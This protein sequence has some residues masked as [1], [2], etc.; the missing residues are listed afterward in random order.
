MKHATGTRFSQYITGTGSIVLKEGVSIEDVRKLLKSQ[1][2]EKPWLAEGVD[3]F[4]VK[5]GVIFILASYER[6]LDASD[7]LLI[8]SGFRSLMASGRLDFAASTGESFGYSISSG[9]K[10]KPGASY[11]IGI[12]IFCG[13]VK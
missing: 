8:F 5:E 3:E 4:L 7:L 12:D 13:E 6:V 2:E 9:G 1:N 10:E 11:T